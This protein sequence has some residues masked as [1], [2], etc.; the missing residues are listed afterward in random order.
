MSFFYNILLMKLLKKVFF[1]IT[2]YYV[3]KDEYTY[4]LVYLN[5]SYYSNTHVVFRLHGRLL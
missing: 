2:G 1:S 3:H 5:N 4:H